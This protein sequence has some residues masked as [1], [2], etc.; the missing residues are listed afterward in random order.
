[1]AKTR[2]LH[3]VV[4][5]RIPSAT[6][7]PS[8]E[9]LDRAKLQVWDMLRYDAVHPLEES[10][11]RPGWLIFGKAY[12]DGHDGMP[13]LARWESFGYSSLLSNLVVASIPHTSSLHIPPELLSEI[14]SIDT[15]WRAL[16]EIR[17]G[18]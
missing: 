5:I 6:A 14:T 4:A 2:K 8:P 1:M 11:R 9:E 10:S 7:F 3:W 17:V 15:A 16:L 12:R 13:T 18:R